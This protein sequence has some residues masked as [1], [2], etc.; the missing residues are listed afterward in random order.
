MIVITAPTSSISK[1]V[2]HS[3]LDTYPDIRVIARDA[4]RIEAA[5]R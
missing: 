3:L 2:L 1:K 4:S 5:D